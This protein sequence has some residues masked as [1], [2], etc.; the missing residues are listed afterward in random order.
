MDESGVINDRGKNDI[1]R[2]A[3]GLRSVRLTWVIGV[4]EIVRYDCMERL[5]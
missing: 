2:V 4:L 1:L 5:F 3:A